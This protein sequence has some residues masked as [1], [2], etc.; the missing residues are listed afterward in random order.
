MPSPGGY[1]KELST[2]PTLAGVF[3]AGIDPATMLAAAVISLLAGGVQ[4]TV[5]FGMAVVSVPLLTLLDPALTPLPQ[6]LVAVPITLWAAWRERAA[7]DLEGIGWIVAGRIPGAALGASIVTIAS[8]RLL[9]GLIATIVIGFALATAG[10]WTVP[11]N[12]GTRATAGFAAGVSGTVSAIGGP[13]LAL[14]YRH[15]A[16]GTVRSSLGAV[17][18]IGLGINLAALVTADA[19]TARDVAVAAWL[20]GPVLAG[21]ALS[22]RLHRWVEGPVLARSITGLSLAA[23]V[24]LAVRALLG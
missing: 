5:G 1:G 10:R 13:P 19:F 3:P 24:A 16:G 11:L 8:D 21:F 4:G 15:S 18:A 20:V 12:R 23:A 17:F 6:L 2:G 22:R 9:D 7:L 14:L